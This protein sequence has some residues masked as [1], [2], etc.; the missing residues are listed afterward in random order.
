MTSAP[1]TPP[2]LRRPRHP[3][4]DDLPDRHRLTTGRFAC[5][6]PLPRGEHK[7]A[8]WDSYAG[9]GPFA[10]HEPRFGLGNA[11]LPAPTSYTFYPDPATNLHDK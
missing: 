4:F 6:C 8:V 11:V 9:T 3:Y 2:S 10:T 1:P 5:H 7:Q